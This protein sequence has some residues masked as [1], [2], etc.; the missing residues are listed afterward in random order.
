MQVSIN[1][2]PVPVDF[3]HMRNL[4]EALAELND[5]FVPPGEQVFQVRVN[6]E[7]FSER[8]PRESRYVSL[9]EINTLEI[10]TIPDVQMAKVILAEAGIQAGILCQAI[11]HCAR[12]FRM[13]NEDE[14]NHYF[15]QMLEALRWL[16]LT[17]EQA[18]RV[19]KVDLMTVLPPHGQPQSR[20]LQRMQAL[21]E[22]MAE[23]HEDLDY[24]LL[25]DLME[26]ELLPMVQEWQA[27]LENLARR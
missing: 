2:K 24:I 27:V 9:K 5:H 25:A 14:A 4:E 11:Q 12:L 1:E 18:C 3:S 13:A 20:Y 10:V 16:L 23:I 8:Y 7:F 6:G 17:G 15:A 21:L 26:Y 19:L 22:E